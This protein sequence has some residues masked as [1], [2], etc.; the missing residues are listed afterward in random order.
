MIKIFSAY[1]KGFSTAVAV[2]LT[3]SHKFTEDQSCSI[4]IHEGS[5]SIV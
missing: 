1:A 4:K 3:H 2:V 5:I